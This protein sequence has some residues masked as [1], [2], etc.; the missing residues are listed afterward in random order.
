[1]NRPSR[2]ERASATTKRYVGCFF[3]PM[4]RS[5]IFTMFVFHGRVILARQSGRHARH[6]PLLSAELFHHLT[7][8]L[9]LFDEPVDV[10][11][12]RA[13]CRARCACG[14]TR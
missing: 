8:L 7:R 6:A 11:D 14:A 4:R 1:M 9:E 13:R 3:A 2:G 12:L 10:G 5:L